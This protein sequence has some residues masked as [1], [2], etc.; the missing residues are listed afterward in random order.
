MNKREK[1]EL[2]NVRKEYPHGSVTNDVIHTEY[3]AYPGHLEETEE[4]GVRLG[5]VEESV[6]RHTT[7]G[8]TWHS[9]DDTE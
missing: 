1:K 8:K 4:E 5:V 3:V 2:K 9:P 6:V 7:D